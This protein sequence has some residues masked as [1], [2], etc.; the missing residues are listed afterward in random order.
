MGCCGPCSQ[1]LLRCRSSW[2][3]T[4]RAG[5]QHGT[6]AERRKPLYFISVFFSSS[7][8][9]AAGRARAALRHRIG[10]LPCTRPGAHGGNS[11][12]CRVRWGRRVRWKRAKSH[13]QGA[14]LG[15]GSLLELGHPATMLSCRVRTAP[16]QTPSQGAAG[17]SFPAD[18]LWDRA[19]LLPGVQGG[20]RRGSPWDTTSLPQHRGSCPGQWLPCQSGDTAHGEPGGNP[21]QLHPHTGAAVSSGDD[22]GKRMGH[23]E[24]PGRTARVVGTRRGLVPS[25]GFIPHAAHKPR[26]GVGGVLPS[27]LAIARDLPGRNG[28]E[29]HGG[30][31]GSQV[32]L[33]LLRLLTVRRDAEP[34]LHAAIPSDGHTRGQPSGVQQGAELPGHGAG[35]LWGCQGGWLELS[36]PCGGQPLGQPPAAQLRSLAAPAGTLGTCWQL[37]L[38]ARVQHLH[39]GPDPALR[40]AAGTPPGDPQDGARPLSLR[41]HAA[42]GPL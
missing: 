2:C 26:G 34:M 27:T 17:A 4:H 25:R 13:G 5:L 29:G 28:R 22:P 18:E 30:A 31:D 32:P 24:E 7:A 42:Q 41:S 35:E 10:A 9:P 36:P 33:G 19:G 23:G 39:L 15:Q 16:K 12:G 38:R 3:E 20:Q 11:W 40:P 6:R 37:G 8:S 14:R 21:P 1:P